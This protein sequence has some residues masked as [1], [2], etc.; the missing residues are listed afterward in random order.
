MTGTPC[1]D[2][3]CAAVGEPHERCS[4]HRKRRDDDGR[5]VPCRN[6]PYHG[7]D[8]CA[9]HA[10][11]KRSA[12]KAEGAAVLEREAGEVAV[13]RLLD[14]EADDFG[15][16]EAETLVQLRKRKQ[17][18]EVYNRLLN[19]F[20]TEHGVEALAV[21]TG[22][23]S[24]PNEVEKH[25]LLAWRDE[26]QQAFTKLLLEARRAGIEERMVELEEQQ[27]TLM[28]A[29]VRAHAEQLEA[30]LIALGVA[31]EVVHVVMAESPALWRAALE[32]TAA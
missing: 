8:A 2:P 23:T 31:V 3:A 15:T 17:L 20:V 14:M 6:W 21:R 25:Y 5:K 13:R 16:L 1:K 4:K 26:A 11:K 7:L 19:E 18:L 30:R 28:E 32:V 29:A 27:L 24:K 22:S 9:M 10:G 12:A